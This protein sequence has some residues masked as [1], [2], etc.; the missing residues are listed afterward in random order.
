MALNRFNICDD[1]NCRFCDNKE[2]E[3]ECVLCESCKD[4]LAD[5]EGQWVKHC[6]TSCECVGCECQYCQ[7]YRE[8][9]E[10]EGP[11]PGEWLSTILG[12]KNE[13]I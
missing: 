12:V 8:S 13:K 11:S 5:E 7:D 4:P 2:G 9:G 3:C 6:S 1:G 10:D